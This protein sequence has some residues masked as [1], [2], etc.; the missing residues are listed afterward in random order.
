MTVSTWKRRWGRGL[1]GLVAMLFFVPGAVQ[2]AVGAE[3]FA[4]ETAARKLG[5]GLAGVT[6][7]VLELP[8]TMAE[9]SEKDGYSKGLS[10]GFAVGLGRLVQRELIGAYEFLSCP[11]PVP[12]DFEPIMGPEFPWDYFL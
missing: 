6:L 5:R 4:E 1:G 9:M 8:G 3:M 7:G 12:E 11:F 2:A 10:L